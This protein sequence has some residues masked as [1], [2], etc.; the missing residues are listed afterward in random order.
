MEFLKL[1]EI[2]VRRKWLIVV[3][4][5]VFLAAVVAGT[6]LATPIYEAKAKLLVEPSDSL[7]SLMSNLGLTT[8]GASR[9]PT[10]TEETYETEIALAQIRPLLEKLISNLNLKDK[11]GEPMKADDLIDPSILNIIFV[12]PSLT[13][14]RY[15]ESDILEIVSSSKSPAEAAK[16]SNELA[17]FYI[18]DM[19]EQ[20]RKEYKAARAFIENRITEIKEKYYASLLEKRDFM[21]EEETVDLSLESTS[22]LQRI[23]SLESSLRDSEV[24][25]VQAE[26]S[27]VLLQEKLGKGEYASTALN[28]QLETTL[29]D[30]L[31]E[32][33]GKTVQYTLKDPDVSALNQ[34]IDTLRKMLKE[35]SQIAF[36]DKEMSI[37]PVYAQLMVNLKDAYINKKTEEIRS[38][39]LKRFIDTAKGDL[40]KIPSKVMKNAQLELVLSNYQTVY[41]NLLQ[42]LT[43]IGVAESMT[44]SNIRLVEPAAEPEVDKP[45]FPKYVLN[46]ILGVVLSV[47]FAFSLALFMEYIDNT[48]KSPADLEGC[49]FTFL[50]SIPGLRSFKRK[51]LI[52]KTD[53]NDPVYEAYRRV[54]SNIYFARLGKPPKT[55]LITSINP[56]AGGSTVAVNLGILCAKEGKKTLLI[57]TDLRRPNL[58][59]LCG[60]TNEEGLTSILLEN[61]EIENVVRKSRID[62]L[63]ILPAGP[64]PS[65]PG[66]LL[67]SG[68]IRDLIGK[69]EKEYDILILDSAPLL[70]KS[71]AITLKSYADDM[72]LISRSKSTTSHAISQVAGSLK[73]AQIKPIGIILNCL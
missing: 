42:Y 64:T 18:E 37:A 48:I 55:L 26:Q 13:V 24:A 58:H 71:D 54:L 7:S 12:E 73:N 57:D 1:W 19:L 72:V 52:S 45:E 29:S 61:K 51:R 46:W 53:S 66:L 9:Q 62:G 5:V 65:D 44:I 28:D 31:V 63:S 36:G 60:C 10:A 70:I 11:D 35:R 27:I 34:Q 14:E 21:I 68:Q 4:F 17:T 22:L 43:E 40:I 59:R 47:F 30:M 49:G 33:S 67:K 16:M 69:L 39:L 38:D 20:T 6:Y 41:A 15:E 32:L 23:S 2:A 50:G 56:K 8:A 3:T 25:G